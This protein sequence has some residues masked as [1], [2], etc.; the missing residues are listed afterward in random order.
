[1]GEAIFLINNVQPKIKDRRRK[2][3]EDGAAALS[4]NL[5]LYIV[6]Q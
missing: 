3:K 5:A 4:N 1:M 6:S 2:A